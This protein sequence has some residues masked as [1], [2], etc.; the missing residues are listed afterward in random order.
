MC[1]LMVTET[2]CEAKDTNQPLFVTFLDSAK[3]FDMVDHCILLNALHDLDID[4][5]LWRLYEDMYGDVTSRVRING[6]LSR[7]IKETR[8]IRQGGET[9]TEGFKAKD[10]A[11][12]NKVSEHP[13]SLRIGSIA[14]GI[15]TVAD[16]NCMLA[17]SH[18][19]AQ[20]QLL[21]AQH[22]AAK[23]RYV[24]SA[25]KSKVVYIPDKATKG[26]HL[27]ALHF[28]NTEIAY[29]AKETHL[30]LTRTDDGK[31]CEAVHDR[32][33]TGR[34][35]AYQLMGAGLRGVNGITPH[36]TKSMVSVYV[37]PALMYGL[38]AL[39]LDE[40]SIDKIDAYH[41]SLL[42]KLQ[43]LPESTAKPAIYLLIGCL[44]AHA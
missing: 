37:C 6:Q 30:G 4:P 29:S 20:T 28:N 22:N 23:S 21:L 7:A 39:S 15:P 1:A 19:G 3:A 13:S 27:P 18:N 35:M 5:F 40:N 43:S 44:P 25:T 12:L 34:R 26:L 14:V 17:S 10:N 16:D 8:G 41:R 32:I 42:R 36:I 24:F 9:S 31:V 33:Q 2:I 11:F 38:E